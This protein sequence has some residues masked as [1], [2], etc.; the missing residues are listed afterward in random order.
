MISKVILVTTTY[1]VGMGELL[2]AIFFWVTHSKSE[3]RKVMALMAFSM[4]TWTLV[5]T[6]TAY[7]SSGA[8]LIL[9][10]QS[11]YIFGAFLLTSF[12]HLAIIFPYK[13]L[14]FD[15][16]HAIL[17]YVPASLL[18]IIAITSNTVV[19]GVYVTGQYDAG[20]IVGGPLFSLYNIFLAVLFVIG[21]SILYLQ[22]QRTDGMRKRNVKLVFWSILLGGL[23]GVYLD[24]IAP[25]FGLPL[26][27]FLYGNL[28]TA[29][30]FSITT[31]IV[32]KK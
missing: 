30:W 19:N 4:A 1:L 27:N 29:I 8:F 32:T 24:L 7:R 3:I 13:L 12:V 9:S 6:F 31:Y 25:V 14:Q 16:L 22:I 20:Q 11:T 28:A 21:L 10:N 18:S 17:L 5:N 26:V 15:R 23:P 2:L